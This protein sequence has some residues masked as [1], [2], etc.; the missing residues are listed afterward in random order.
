[1]RLPSE[2]GH[3]YLTPSQRCAGELW[4][5]SPGDFRDVRI[6]ALVHVFYDKVVRGIVILDS[7]RLIPRCVNSFYIPPN[8]VCTVSLLVTEVTS[9]TPFTISAI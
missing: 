7:S 4:L 1:M 3:T 8:G 2:C 9:G 5:T 6:A